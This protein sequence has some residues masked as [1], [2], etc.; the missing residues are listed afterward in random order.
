MSFSEVIMG[1]DKVL[2]FFKEMLSSLT[3]DEIESSYTLSVFKVDANSLLTVFSILERNLRK[4]E[5]LLDLGCGYGF[6]AS[7]IADALD[8]R[9]AYGVDLDLER[10]K[11]AGERLNVVRV[12]L[13]NGY[14]PFP[15]EI[16]DLVICFGVLD[17]LKFFDNVFSETYRVLNKDGLLLIS[18]TN[19]GSWDSRICSMLGYQPRHVEV[20]SKYLVG[21]PK[22]YHTVP[23][24]VGHIHACTLGA[25]K[26]LASIYGF[27]TVWGAGLKTTHPNRLVRLIDA[28][29]SKR[30]SLATRYLLLLRKRIG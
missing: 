22:I 7:F 26:E 11:K 23:V 20:S 10:L 8:F 13:E 14:L 6:L 30:P 4:K 19:L 3:I 28:V 17:H 21:V 25:I 16:F 29:L 27:M 9:E 12:D 18:C 24:P 2:S 5:K 15:N 1:K